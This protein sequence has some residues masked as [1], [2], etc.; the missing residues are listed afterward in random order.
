MTK[1]SFYGL[2]NVTVDFLCIQIVL[3]GLLHPRQEGEIAV[4]EIKLDNV[5]CASSGM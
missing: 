1:H 5:P 2:S 4:D 3:E